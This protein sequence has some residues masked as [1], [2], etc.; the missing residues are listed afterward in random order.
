[1]NDPDAPCE[2]Q[3]EDLMF[4]KPQRQLL[5]QVLGRGFITRAAGSHPLQRLLTLKLLTPERQIKHT[6]HDS[7]GKVVTK[8]L[9]LYVLTSLGKAVAERLR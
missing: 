8:M 2:V 6:R 3:P 4:T 7:H 9:T 5:I 1:M